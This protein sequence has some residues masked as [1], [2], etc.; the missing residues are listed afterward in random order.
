M[1]QLFPSGLSLRELAPSCR[2]T[3]S[4]VS[5]AAPVTLAGKWKQSGCSPADWRIVNTCYIYAALPPLRDRSADSVHRGN[6]STDWGGGGRGLGVLREHPVNDHIRT[7]FKELDQLY[8]GWVK[9]YIIWGTGG[10]NIQDEQSAEGLG[11]VQ[12]PLA[13]GSISGVSGASWTG[14][15]QKKGSWTLTKAVRHSTGREMGFWI[16]QTKSEKKSC[17]SR[18]PLRLGGQW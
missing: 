2:D 11:T 7:S 3:Y 5:T 1:T 16:P 4:S 9:A 14:S 6:A 13:W 17:L 12:P 8:L 10:R 15:F 18:V